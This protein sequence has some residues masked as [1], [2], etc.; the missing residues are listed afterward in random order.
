MQV[1]C[2]DNV[3]PGLCDDNEG[4]EVAIYMVQV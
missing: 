3:L 1:G 4:V 2:S